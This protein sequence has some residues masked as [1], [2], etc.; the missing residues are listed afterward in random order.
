MKVIILAGGKGSRLGDASQTIPK[1]LVQIGGLPIIEHIVKKYIQYEF[2]EF[3]VAAGYLWAEMWNWGER[4]RGKYDVKIHVVD[5]GL[6]TQ[7]GGRLKQ[8]SDELDGDDFMFTYGDGIANIDLSALYKQHIKTG[9]LCTVTAVRPPARFGRIQS[10]KH[11]RVTDF[12]EKRQVDEGWINGGFF[13]CNPNVLKL[14]QDD[15]IAWEAR[16]MQALVSMG[17]LYTYKHHGFWHCVDTQHDVQVIND[18]IKEGV[19]W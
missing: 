3:I 17:E 11:K 4:T 7:T 9:G 6:E 16:P 5:T 13:V 14:I 10:D 12:T 15:T 2:T 1:P 8:V 19:T 18:L